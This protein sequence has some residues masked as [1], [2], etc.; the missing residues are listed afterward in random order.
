MS[1]LAA[2]LVVTATV[3]DNAISNYDACDYFNELG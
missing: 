2:Q 3:F 1:V